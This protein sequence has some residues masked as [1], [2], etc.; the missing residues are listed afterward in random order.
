[1][2]VA[3]L[4]HLCLLCWC[5][6]QHAGSEGLQPGM[7]APGGLHTHATKWRIAESASMSAWK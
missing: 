6:G 2:G 4:V 5:K 1:M 7:L 3:N